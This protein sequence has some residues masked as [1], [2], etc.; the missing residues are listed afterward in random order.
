MNIKPIS[1]LCAV[2]AMF[3]LVK[4]QEAPDWENP[5]VFQINKEPTRAS[6]MP[7]ADVPSAMVDEYSR[8]PWYMSLD[9][10]WKFQWSPTPGQRPMDFYKADFDVRNWKEI[11]VPSN[12]E[13]KGYGIPIYTNITYPYPK[14]PPLIDHS[15]NPV[16]SY[17]R[18]FSLPENWEGRRVYIHFEAGTSAM[19]VWVNGQKV[20]YT[21]NSKTPAEFDITPYVKKGQNL[22]AAE[23][24]RWS[25][26]SYL[27]DQDFWRLSGIDRHVYLYSTADVRVAD[28]FVRPDLDAAYKNGSLTVDVALKSYA[29]SAK[30]NYQLEAQLF[31]ANGGKVFAQTLKVVLAADGSK[32]TTLSQKVPS[33]KLWSNETPYLYSLVLTLKDDKGAA[34][35]HV[36]AKVGFRKV[37]LKNGQLLVNGKR[38]LVK[39]VNMHEHHPINGHY[40]SKE[41][42]MKDICVMKSLNINAVRCSHY[43]SNVEWMKL[44]DQYGLFLVAE[45]NIES[46]GMGAE[47]QAWFDKKVHPAYRDEWKAAHMDRITSL[48]ERDKNH[49]SVII[50]SM[51]NECGNGPVFYEAYKWIKERDRTRLVQFEQAGENENT[52]VVCPM[53]PRIRDMKEYA[54]RKSVSRPYIMCEYAHAMGNSSGNF[55]EYWRIIRNSPNMQGG[56]IWEWVE[57]GLMAHDEVG[58]QYWAY[59]GDLGGH[60]YTNDENFCLDGLV[61]ADRIPHPGTFEVKKFYQNIWFKSEKPE[62][63]VITVESEFDYTNL[64]QFVFRYEVVKNGGIVKSGDF[65]VSLEPRGKKQVKLDLPKLDQAPGVEYLLNIYA[66][67]RLGSGILPQNHEMAREQMVLGKSNY[68]ETVEA[69]GTVPTV[70]DEKDR[71]R[72]TAAGVEVIIDKRSGLIQGFRADGKWFFGQKPT[73]NFWRAPVDNDFG[74]HMQR[75]SNVWRVAGENRSLKSIDVKIEDNKA[76]VIANL[77]LRDVASDYSIVYTMNPDGILDVDVTYKAGQDELPEIPRFGMLMTLDKDYDNLV[78][79]GRGPWENYADRNNASHIG[80]YKSKVAEQYV[81]YGRPQENGYKTDVRW[82][83]LTNDDGKGIKIEGKQPLGMS[84]LH[85]YPLDFDPGINKAQRHSSDIT[86]RNEV[87]LCIDLAQRGVGGDDSWGARPHEQYLLKGKEYSYGFRISFHN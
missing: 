14:N 35:E 13:L 12:W 59:G 41:M 48:V 80:I 49:P 81:P 72:M 55:D 34:L 36:S 64:D 65:N 23:V 54:E 84:A 30:N 53:Y 60:T 73:P 3:S 45:A 70:N 69:N 66:Y 26:G 68:F 71:V 1:L 11:D 39:G 67:T 25:D 18:T 38:I 32:S 87:V 16:G 46:H 86:F 8:S 57:H 24:Y 2:L 17:R 62:S 19:Y 58:R 29:P 83:T 28:F 20:G 63:G 22:V 6:F 52:D 78:Y 85:N 15:D 31:D 82:I 79:Y 61:S 75:I 7:Y 27:E 44:C 37:E 4:A 40:Q 33:P 76:V 74:N 9:G 47:W 42:M 43:P 10:K 50:W 77:W 21:E 51:G 5:D 56:F